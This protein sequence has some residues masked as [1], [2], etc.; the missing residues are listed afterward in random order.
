MSIKLG[1]NQKRRKK[2]NYQKYR[3]EFRAK[4]FKNDEKQMY[5]GGKNMKKEFRTRI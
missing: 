2:R 1:M 3:E 5:A 4:R